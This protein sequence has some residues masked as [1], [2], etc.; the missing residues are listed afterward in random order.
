MGDRW[1]PL[2]QDLALR[3]NQSALRLAVDVI[4]PMQ[5]IAAVHQAFADR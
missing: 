3:A 2:L 5:G 1:R 4:Y